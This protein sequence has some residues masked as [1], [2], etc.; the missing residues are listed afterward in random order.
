MEAETCANIF[1][2]AFKRETICSYAEF[3][4]V[5]KILLDSASSI[6]QAETDGQ[7]RWLTYQKGEEIF[8]I[9]FKDQDVYVDIPS[10]TDEFGNINKAKADSLGLVFSVDNPFSDDS[11]EGIAL[12]EAGKVKFWGS[13]YHQK[14]LAQ[15]KKE[16]RDYM[17][18][19][20]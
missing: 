20:R 12:N 11:P 15:L 3:E 6:L 5:Y 18:L 8:H 9:V 2:R 14:I 10:Y 4:A 19:L 13:L 7:D 1:A 17:S 16:G